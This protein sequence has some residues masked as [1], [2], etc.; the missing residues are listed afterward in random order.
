MIGNWDIGQEDLRELLADE[1]EPA[2]TDGPLP[3]IVEDVDDD[4]EDDT[5]DL[6]RL[7]SPAGTAATV[8]ETPYPSTPYP[9]TPYQTPMPTRRSERSRNPPER[10]NFDQR[11]MPTKQEWAAMEQNHNIEELEDCLHEEYTD[12]RLMIIAQ[13]MVRLHHGAQMLGSEIFACYGQQ[14]VYERGLKLFGEEG[15]EAAVKEMDQMVRRVCFTPIDPAELSESE[16]KKAQDA[17][18]LLSQKKTGEK[19][20]RLVFNGAGTRGFITKEEAASPTVTMESIQITSVIDA[21]ERRDKMTSD[22]PNAF[23]QAYV[24]ETKKGEDRIIMKI[25][26]K[27]VDM[28]LMLAPEIYGNFVVYENGR[29]VIY[30]QVLR[31]IYGMLTAALHWYN[32]LRG[33]MEEEGF[34][35]NPYDPC[36]ANRMVNGKQHTVLFHVDD[37]KSSH[38]DPKVNDDFLEFLNR[39]YGALGE[40]K[41]TRGNVH[42]YLGMTIDFSDDGKVKFDMRSYVTSMIEEFQEFQPLTKPATTPA[43]NDLFDVGSGEELTREQRELFHRLVAKGL[44]LC[45]RSR[46]D[47]HLAITVLAT[48]VK[49]PNTSDWNKLVRLMRY[50]LGTREMVLTLSADNL[51]TIKWYVDASFAVHPDFRSHTGAVMKLGRDGAVISMSAKQK[52]NTRSS[53]EA[54]LVGADDAATKILWT[55]LFLEAQGYEVKKN[56]LCQDNKS[57]ILL[58]ETGKRSSGKRTRALNIR[59]FFLTDQRD[60]GNLSVEYCPTGDMIG[61]YFTKPKQG[62][63]F[64]RFRSAIMGGGV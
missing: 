19:K 34:V 37:L 14:H 35:F 17:M 9:S 54:E 4:E 5:E 55:K 39:K 36:V 45:K 27:L 26:G 33:D 10:L 21:I 29:K 59:Y 46:P 24:P 18:M 57:T 8:P 52:L 41:A 61:D 11:T 42:D 31:A 23:I 47:I 50:L 25:K 51:H 40:V 53:C 64:R 60:K 63:D 38:V 56:I 32:Q 44:F 48:R 12:D 62:Q 49:A 30:V 43:A 22:V 2:P 28:L 15:E 20:G 6:L 3:T 13:L 58:L 7:V 16:F 1:M